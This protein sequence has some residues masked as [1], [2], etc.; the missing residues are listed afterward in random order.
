[1]AGGAPAGAS[2]SEIYKGN[3]P[4]LLLPAWV[5]IGIFLVMPVGIMAVY[6]FLTKEFRG[7]VIWEFTWA[8]YDQFFLNRGLFGDEP[9]SIEWTYIGIFWRSIWQ[10]GL[11]TVLCLLIGFPTAWFIATRAAKERSVWLFLITVPY[12][13]NLL[14]RT[15]S[16]KFLIRDTGPLNEFLLALGVI[17]APLALV[18]TN[19]AVQLGLFY[20][21]LPFMVLPIYAAVERYDFSLSE[22]AADLY[23]SSWQTLRLV[24]L[25]VVKPGIVAGCILVFVPSLGAFLAPDLLGGAKTFMIGSLIEEQFK[26][27]AGNWPFGAAASMILL[28]IV[29]GV[30]LIHA[31]AQTKGER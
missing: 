14:I 18:N 3:G 15:V 23:A 13:V 2:N 1:M 7:G 11:A 5:F 8:A 21:Y 6:S 4:K 19:F 26:G 20:S 31:R 27:A 17:D 29:M 25:P 12:W 22:A 30:L 16:M 9:P 10:A 28:T 24:I